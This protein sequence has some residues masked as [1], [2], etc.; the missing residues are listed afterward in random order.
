MLVATLVLAACRGNSQE[1]EATPSPGLVERGAALYA[2]NCSRCHGFDH[3]GSLKDI[4]PPH[5]ANGHTWHHPDQQLIEVTLNGIDFAV[6]GQPRM[7]PFKGTLNESDVRAILA[8]I[9][10]WWTEEQTQWQTTVTA[11]AT[12]QQ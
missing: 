7:P 3:G 6:E 12:E 10:T 1:H 9:K 2:A 4:P 5:N 8:Y 11:Q